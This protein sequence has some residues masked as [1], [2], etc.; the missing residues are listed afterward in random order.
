V[1]HAGPQHQ[2]WV[3]FTSRVKLLVIGHMGAWSGHILVVER[4]CGIVVEALGSAQI[5]HHKS[6]IT[7]HTSHMAATGWVSRCWELL[8]GGITDCKVTCM[9][10]IMHQTASVHHNTT[11]YMRL[12]RNM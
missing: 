5:I 6:Y 11:S 7:N 10:H 8:A 12:G 4:R 1:W 2:S 9:G 3:T